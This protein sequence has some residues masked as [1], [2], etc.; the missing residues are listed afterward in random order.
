M[1]IC[2]LTASLMLVSRV[3]VGPPAPAQQS[4]K[5]YELIRESSVSRSI[6]TRCEAG[7][8]DWMGHISSFHISVRRSCTI[9]RRKAGNLVDNQQERSSIGF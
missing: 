6:R 5:V 8:A 3:G 2:L 7:D 9:E 4:T 1:R